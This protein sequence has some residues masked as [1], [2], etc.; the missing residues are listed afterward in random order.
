MSKNTFPY[1]RIVVK[2]GTNLLTSGGECLDMEAISR[3][4]KQVAA[5]HQQGLELTIVSS[6]AIAAGRA[7]LKAKGKLKGIPLRQ[8]LA[9]VGQN[10]LMNAY[11]NVFSQHDAVIAQALLSKT[12]LADRIG[13]LNARKTLLSLLELGVICIVNENDVISTDELDE[14]CFGDNDNLSAM[15]ANL[16]DADLLLI[17]TD[18]EGLYTAD[19]RLNPT[20]ELI[21]E[22]ERVDDR[23][24]RL[25]ATTT[26]E[27]ATGGMITKIEAARVANSSGI[28]VIIAHGCQDDIITR[29]AGGEA[30]GT[31]FHPLTSKMESR[32]RWMV[33]GISNK[34]QIVVDRGAASALKSHKKSLLPSGIKDSGGSFQR[35]DVVTITDNKERIIGCGITNYS[36]DDI[37]KIKG[38][39]SKKIADI[40]GHD[41]GAEVVHRN[42][43]AVF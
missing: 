34:G 7:K 38:E 27:L 30:V 12:D 25:A 16:V 4:V 18:T 8:V 31:L 43:L 39:H 23:I 20:A 19:P 1:K 37:N 5:L 32:K 2:I 14:E 17:L 42:N 36:S 24:M 41:Y 28:A 29:V 33:S 13:Y 9:S 3:L 21:K 15:V 6:G 35:G 11:E 22:V 10:R 26:N 40:L